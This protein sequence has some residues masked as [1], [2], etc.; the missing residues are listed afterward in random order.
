[1]NTS[2]TKS[3]TTPVLNEHEQNIFD[4]LL[5][6][7]FMTL[8]L[9]L[10]IGVGGAALNILII[11]GLIHG[12]TTGTV[13]SW[14]GVWIGSVLGFSS[15]LGVIFLKPLALKFIAISRAKNVTAS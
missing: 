4:A 13:W 3:S 10:G 15:L 12:D 5:H 11:N 1:M 2:Q 14:V 7:M 9:G 6:P 8:I